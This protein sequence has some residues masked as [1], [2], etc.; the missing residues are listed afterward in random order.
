M[1]RRPSSIN[2][3][4]ES[5]GF[6]DAPSG[7]TDSG[8]SSSGGRDRDDDD[9]DVPSSSISRR[10][11]DGL[12]DD[13]ATTGGGGRGN[14]PGDTTPGVDDSSD[15]ATRNDGQ[16]SRGVGGLGD[17][18]RIERTTVDVG[19][20]T[21]DR[22]GAVTESLSGDG[23]A[24]SDATLDPALA[25]GQS[26]GQEIAESID[27][28]T[29]TDV[30]SRD[31]TIDDGV[32]RL[33]DAALGTERDAREQQQAETARE[34]LRDDAAEQFGTP[35]SNVDIRRDGDRFVAEQDLTDGQ[36][37]ID[38]AT[39]GR[40]E[41]VV[42]RGR[43][44]RERAAAPFE[45]AVDTGRDTRARLQD[46]F[47]DVTDTAGDVAA[48]GRSQLTDAGFTAGLSDTLGDETGQADRDD[49][50]DVS[51]REAAALGA[52][53]VVTP[54]PS[55]SV[56]GG[57]IAIGAAGALA[58]AEL[59]RR[60]QRG[61]LEAPED[62][63]PVFSNEVDVGQINPTSELTTPSTR[64]PVATTEFGT[65]DGSEPVTGTEIGV[66]DSPPAQTTG[67]VDVPT[68]T[69]TGVQQGRQRQR[70]E[71]NGPL[72]DL[73]SEELDRMRERGEPRINPGG[74]ISRVDVERVRREGGGVP[75]QFYDPSPEQLVGVGDGTSVFDPTRDPFVFPG[76][77]AVGTQPSTETGTGVGEGVG[78][79]TG[80]G[81]GTGV[82]AGSG[83]FSGVG[84]GI[85][86]QTEAATESREQTRQEQQPLQQ[87][88]LLRETAPVNQTVEQAAATGGVFQTGTTTGTTTTNTTGGP[89]G[90]RTT[91]RLRPRRPDLDTDDDDEDE[92]FFGVDES[93]DL[94]DSD[95]L[96][97]A[98]AARDVLGSDPVD[99]GRDPF[100]L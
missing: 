78:T 57:V 84:L 35:E 14:R 69:A 71:N 42:D 91:P 38:R 74:D 25:G 88:E 89:G 67:E 93:S 63:E 9:D 41:G 47:G 26:R 4:A 81:V 19:S 77:G 21:R 70:E 86:E 28:Q 68:V 62:R 32:A 12:D 75:S 79:G 1:S 99:D 55:T 72:E 16:A 46:V 50:P 65:P 13:P 56:G 53:G 64:E 30:T 29:V 100:R 97:G 73:L 24:A 87:T 33:T 7:G 37:L 3:Y 52:A 5:G 17:Q 22:G 44:L 10:R 23:Y 80:T 20:I 58:A 15:D 2:S 49:L 6:D 27:R 85:G 54:E 94:F 39:G 92:F 11:D 98:E 43:E 95:I 60:R 51:A 76:G 31:V 59:Q 34:Q 61:E 90:P 36:Q 45:P 66:P 96:G 83:L 40:F 18:T 82:G 8:S 48:T